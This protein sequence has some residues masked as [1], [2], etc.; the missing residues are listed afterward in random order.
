MLMLVFKFGFYVNHCRNMFP[1]CVS[2][3][4]VHCFK[5]YVQ[6]Y[7]WLLSYLESKS[8]NRGLTYSSFTLCAYVV[9]WFHM[10]IC[11]CVVGHNTSF[12]KTW[13]HVATLRSLVW[14]IHLTM[15]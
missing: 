1:H 15:Q 9:R 2:E 14:V 7:K 8:R 4:I 11:N 6:S 5:H 10:G 13:T 12:L 3:N